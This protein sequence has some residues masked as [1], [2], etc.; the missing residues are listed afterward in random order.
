MQNVDALKDL[1]F[2]NDD[3]VIVFQELL[4]RIH[5]YYSHG[6][7]VGYRMTRNEQQVFF[8]LKHHTS[9][10]CGIICWLIRSK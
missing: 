6:F 5:C 3:E 10:S 7:D 2:S 9:K 4:D 8:N 1:Y